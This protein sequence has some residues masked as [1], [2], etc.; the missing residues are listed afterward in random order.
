[1]NK[2]KTIKKE[3]YERASLLLGKLFEIESDVTDQI[4]T[5]IQ[6]HGVELFFKNLETFDFSLDIF[7]K[8]N[9]VRMVLNGIMEG[10]KES[11][12]KL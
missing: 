9:A 11:E 10:G 12:E 4:N 6:Y 2:D 7:E 3:D 8:L 1:M 5:C